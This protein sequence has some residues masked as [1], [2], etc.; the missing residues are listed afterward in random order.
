MKSSESNFQSALND[1][2]EARLLASMQEVLARLTGKSNELLSYEE[3]ARKLK[4]NVRAER[5]VFDIPINSIVGSVGRYSDFNRSFLPLMGNEMERQRWARVK[6]AIDDPSSAGWPPIDVYKVGDV[7]FV[8]DG[9]HRVSVARREGFN[10]IQ[11]HVVEV[12]TEIPITP[13][14]QPDDLIIKAE[15]ADFL[16][17]TDFNNLHPGVD[18]SLTVPGQYQRLL[19]HIELHRYYMGLDFLRDIS[20]SEGVGHWYD[21]VYLPIIQPLRE[22]GL[23]RWFPNRTETD[24]YLWVS[25]HRAALEKE[26]GWRVRPEAAVADLAALENPRAERD[27]SNTGSWRLT[28]MVDRYTDRLF[29]DILVPLSGE[30]ESWQALDQAV[31]IAR[32]EKADLHGIHVISPNSSGNSGDT[33]PVQTGFIQRCQV[34]GI[35]GSLVVEKGNVPDTICHRAL[36]TDLVVLNVAHPPSGGL[37]SLGSGLRSI[38]WRSARPILTVPGKTSTMDRILIAFDGSTKAREAVFVATYLAER[39]K[40]SLTVLTISDDP[41][42]K[43]QDYVRDYLELHEVPADFVI[44]PGAREIF[45]NVIKDREINLVVMGGYSGNAWQEVI[46]G[47]AVNF[48]LRHAACPLLICR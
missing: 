41:A 24:L 14:I 35:K 34:A 38:I 42:T 25:E 15:Y 23:L 29:R 30:P 27:A 39:I 3:V 17:R 28:K 36:L 43:I 4:L 16:D 12:K 32:T 13:E 19:D 9:N 2:N 10:T 11:A 7:Y 33:L 1:F 45:L 21:T 37:S 26:L 31:F 8:L 20:Y 6:V 40:S 22:R 18:L 46:I 5:G 48:L 47:S 44:T